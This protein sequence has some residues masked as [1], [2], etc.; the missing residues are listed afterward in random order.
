MATNFRQVG[1]VLHYEVQASDNIKS[2]D[3]VAV[4]D[5]VGVAIN[6]GV[7]GELLAVSVQGVYEVPVPAAAGTIAQ[8]KEVYYDTTA[9]EITLTPTG[10][11]LIGWAW[12]AGDAGET[13]PVKLRF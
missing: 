3:L 7:E 5:V 4:N 9:K 1:E 13:V 10:N 8:G 2:G 6:D 12:E 11:I